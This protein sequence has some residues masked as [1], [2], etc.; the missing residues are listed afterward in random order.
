MEDEMFL[1][2]VR[3][4]LV[5]LGTHPDLNYQDSIC[6]KNLGIRYCIKSGIKPYS[7]IP[8]NDPDSYQDEIL[9]KEVFKQL[10]KV[11]LLEMSRVLSSI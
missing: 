6:L 1:H 9:M 4:V 10:E 5:R 7:D 8:L 11:D 2:A 3:V